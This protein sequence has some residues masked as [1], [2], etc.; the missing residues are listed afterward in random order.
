LRRRHLRSANRRSTIFTLRDYPNI[1][2][3]A[4]GANVRYFISSPALRKFFPHVTDDDVYAIVRRYVHFS[5]RGPCGEGMYP[6]VD[7]NGDTWEFKFQSFCNSYDL[8]T[9]E[10]PSL[11]VGG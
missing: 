7:A 4:V 11:V 1:G 9:F 6:L 3:T 5:K 2:G 10:A 8:Q